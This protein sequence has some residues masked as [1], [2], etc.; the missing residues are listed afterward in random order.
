[1]IDVPPSGARPTLRRW[2]AG[3]RLA[4]SGMPLQYRALYFIHFRHAIIAA[5][6]LPRVMEFL[7]RQRGEMVSS[8]IRHG[9]PAYPWSADVVQHRPQCEGRRQ[10]AEG[11][12]G[13]VP[14]R[15]HFRR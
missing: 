10:H 5:A 13:Q 14:R 6:L 9:T 12:M 15:F 3:S 7:D 8:R 11:F 4:R 2:N 1:M